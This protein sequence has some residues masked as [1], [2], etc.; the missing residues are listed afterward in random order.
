MAP[1][2]GCRARNVCR[3]DPCQTAAKTRWAK[4]GPRGHTIAVTAP[5]LHPGV[6]SCSRPL[7]RTRCAETRRNGCEPGPYGVLVTGTSTAQ[8]CCWLR[9]GSKPLAMRQWHSGEHR[10]TASNLGCSAAG[11]PGSSNLA[12]PRSILQKRPRESTGMSC[13]TSEHPGPAPG[14]CIRRR[15][16]SRAWAGE[17][18]GSRKIACGSVSM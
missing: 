7:P 17:E 1:R 3:T 14:R 12:W 9:C 2:R 15:P 13:H 6:L 4:Q 11:G 10:P 18:G 8:G 16:W 5:R